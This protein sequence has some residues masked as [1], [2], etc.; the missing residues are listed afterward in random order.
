MKL[1]GSVAALPH[2]H[3]H[4]CLGH[5]DRDCC[6]IRYLRS[7]IVEG[8]TFNR[9]VPASLPGASLSILG[10]RVARPVVLL[11]E[12]GSGERVSERQ[13]L[14]VALARC[15][16]CKG[17]FRLLPADVLPHKRYGLAVIG[18]ITASHVEANK[19]L[20]TAAWTTHT[21]QTPAHATLHAWTEGLGAF[22]LGRSFGCLPNAH[23]YQAIVAATVARWSSL[24]TKPLRPA[25]ID[26]HR[27]RSEARGE[28]LL[29]VA[30]VL[31]LAATVID[32]ATLDV[33]LPNDQSPLCRWRQLAIGLGAPAPFAFRTGIKCTPFEHVISNDPES[34]QLLQQ[35]G[36]SVCET[37]SRS[38]PSDSS[39]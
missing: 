9:A 7:R 13:I 33:D 25:Q 4:G 2:G 35:T 38:P 21:G 16:I 27:Y 32:I 30:N 6:H 11:V 5:A 24:D 17:R 15:R 26:P 37:R 14:S 10:S 8:P 34:P 23:P 18:S 31:A 3:R 20:R 22:V 29:A 39:R 1:W 19:S 28:R 36:D 12:D